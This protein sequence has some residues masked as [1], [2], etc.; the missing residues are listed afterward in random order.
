MLENINALSNSKDP[1]YE[2]FVGKNLRSKGFRFIR[3]NELRIGDLMWIFASETIIG[4]FVL[5]DIIQGTIFE[6]LDTQTGEQDLVR[7]HSICIPSVNSEC[8]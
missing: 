6:Y 2:N 4:P 3:S 8:T 1:Y 7:F 5:V